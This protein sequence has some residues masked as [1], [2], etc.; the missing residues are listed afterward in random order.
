MGKIMNAIKKIYNFV[1]TLVMT[2]LLSSLAAQ[3]ALAA[4]ADSTAAR[5]ARLV[6]GT[7]IPVLGGSVGETFRTVSAGVSYLK[8]VFGIGS[9]IMIALL[10]LPVVITI[11]LTRFTF[12]LGAGLA[13]MLGCSAEA[14]ALENL[15]EVYG[16]MLAV[17]SGVGV[18]FIMA[19]CI[20]MQ[21]V[22]AVA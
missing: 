13:D 8:N 15:G 17:V 6:S 9:I 3:T 5:T 7:M 14:R 4:A 21:S 22:I 10:V 19:L 12:L 11:V 20:F 18:M 2:V 1:L 16:T